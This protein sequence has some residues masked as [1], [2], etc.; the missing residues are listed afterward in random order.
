[1]STS[2]TKHDFGRTISN[3]ALSAGAM[4]LFYQFCSRAAQT[5]MRSGMPLITFEILK[6]KS[7]VP[8]ISCRHCNAMVAIVVFVVQLLNNK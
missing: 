7:I 4:V 5:T 3:S 2:D 1:V 8:I 6:L